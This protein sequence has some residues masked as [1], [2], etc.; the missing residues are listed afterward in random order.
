MADHKPN[1]AP[2]PYRSIGINGWR[3]LDIELV[4]L[5]AELGFNDLQITFVGSHFD[6]Y[7]DFR[8]R[9]KEKGLFEL[10][11]RYGMT[12]SLWIR[13]FYH[14]NCRWGLPEVDN[15][16][17]WEGLYRRYAGLADLYPEVDTFVL[18]L[19]ESDKWVAA[20][21]PPVI[22]RAANAIHDA[23]RAAGKGLIVRTFTWHRE[24][25]MNVG[26]AIPEMDEEI[27]ISTKCVGNDW[28]Y[29][30]PHHP[31][32][33]N[34]AGRKQIV[35]M[36]LFGTWQREHYVANGLADEIARRFAYWTEGG[37]YGVF[38]PPDGRTRQSRPIGNAQEG[39]LWVIGRLA[40]GERDVDAIWRRFAAHRFGE[41]AADAMAEAL[42]PTGE[43]VSE[44]L[45]V[46]REYFAHPGGRVPALRMMAEGGRAQPSSDEDA[47]WMPEDL[48]KFD[49][50]RNPFAINFSTWRWDPSYIPTYHQ[51][52]KGAPQVIADKLE[53]VEGQ[54]AS[55]R[56]SLA[57]LEKAK[58]DLPLDGYEYSRFKLQEN[59]FLLQVMTEM[60]L[61]WLKASQLL[62]FEQTEAAKRARTREIEG[63]L[64]ELERLNGRC[65]EGLRVRWQG[66]DYQ[67][68]RGEY[69]NIPG[70]IDEF[71]HYWGMKTG[72]PHLPRY[73][74]TVETMYGPVEV[75]H[76]GESYYMNWMPAAKKWEVS[77][78]NV[79][80]AVRRALTPPEEPVEM[81]G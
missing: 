41:R 48:E 70:F 37:A 49:L 73:E 9:A 57:A 76:V 58:G 39:N 68:R 32:I 45:H 74:E 18:T 28:N 78:R 63:H 42:R 25:A 43:V 22:A 50:Q 14:Q 31:L 56:R 30:Q 54:L 19:V 20:C 8:A 44:A 17:Y 10:G 64:A 77:D 80:W 75:V 53:Q 61:A 23:L 51:I 47:E 65:T 15:D 5:S 66:I 52:R 35:E 7:F 12:A 67:M 27:L 71:Q 38:V 40:A 59:L 69:L 62:Y 1:A 72:E 16:R 6:L 79:I 11:A 26:Q 21:P 46:D 13:E 29:R 55:A 3:P 24:L 4:E 2:M 36:N 81:R 33:G 60:E 34:V